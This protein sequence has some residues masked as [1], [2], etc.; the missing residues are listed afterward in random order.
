MTRRTRLNA[1]LAAI[2]IALAAWL[3]LSRSEPPAPTQ[4]LLHIARQ[5]ISRIEIRSADAKAVVL[6]REQ[7]R[8][9]LLQPVHARANANA[10]KAVLALATMA[11][12]RR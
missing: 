3:W 2:A 11:P 8:W 9:R 7:G 10:I 1:A 12:A 6:G 5:D 4:P